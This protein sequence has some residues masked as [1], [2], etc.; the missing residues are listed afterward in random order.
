MR[1]FM[2]VSIFYGL[3]YLFVVMSN[4]LSISSMRFFSLHYTQLFTDKNPACDAQLNAHM[5]GFVV[6]V[7]STNEAINDA[8]QDWKA[9]RD[10]AQNFSS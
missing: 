8:S 5:Q 10:N 2:R 3:A 1:E 4:V 6:I 7:V 9:G